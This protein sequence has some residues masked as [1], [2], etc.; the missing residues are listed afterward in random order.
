MRELQTGRNRSQSVGTEVSM[1]R[2]WGDGVYVWLEEEN[3]KGGK[4]GCGHV[5]KACGPCGEE[6]R[7]G[8]SGSSETEVVL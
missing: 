6:V 5:H 7:P 2:G 3:R 4:G 1:S 8:R